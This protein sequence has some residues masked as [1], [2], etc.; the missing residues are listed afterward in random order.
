MCWLLHKRDAGLC[1]SGG[2]TRASRGLTIGGSALF[3]STEGQLLT[4]S[5][6]DYPAPDARNRG[7]P[8]TIERC[9]T[10]AWPTVTM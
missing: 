2:G 5:W 6:L 3:D 7:E 8:L 4:G 10:A 9:A 1:L